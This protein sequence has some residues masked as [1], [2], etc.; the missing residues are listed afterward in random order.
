MSEPGLRSSVPLYDALAAGYEEHFQVAHRRAYDDLAWELCGEA[1]PPPPAAVVDVGCGVGRWSRRLLAD[2]YRVTGIEPAPAMAARAA[3]LGGEFTLHRAAVEDVELPERTAG[4]VIAMGSL[5]YTRDPAA[6]IA[7]CAGWLRRGGVLCVLVDSLVALALELL[8]AGR[9]AEALERLDTRRG[10]W[11]SHGHEADLHLLDA[12]TLCQ[13]FQAAGLA[14]DRCAGL[15]VGA[16]A[17]GIEAMATRLAA[18]PG[19][20]LAEERALA[21]RPDLADLGKQL[22]VIGSR[23]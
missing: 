19:A 20:V 12:A 18:D 21:A 23:T 13:A 16:S 7:R 14:V 8:R 4:A 2:G 1:L 3:R 17:H 22:L 9:T 5:Q 15:L 6:T 11:R 10:L